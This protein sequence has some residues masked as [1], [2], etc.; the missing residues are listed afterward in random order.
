MPSLRLLTAI[1]NVVSNAEPTV[2]FACSVS[3]GLSQVLG[4]IRYVFDSLPEKPLVA[5][6]P[7]Q[8]SFCPAGDTGRSRFL[9]PLR[10]VPMI[11]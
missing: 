6:K 3:G 9:G 7:H 11:V 4:P 10:I 2:V 8:S 1:S 5:K